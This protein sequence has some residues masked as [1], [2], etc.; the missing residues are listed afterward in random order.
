V[1]VETLGGLGRELELV[2]RGTAR[3]VLQGAGEAGHGDAMTHAAFVVCDLARPVDGDA[4]ARLELARAEH[5]DGS[6]PVREQDPLGGSASVGQQRVGADGEDGGHVARRR[7]AADVPDRVDAAVEAVPVPVSD[8]PLQDAATHIEIAQ[9]R[10][11][12]ASVLP[13]GEVGDVVHASLRHDL[14]VVMPP[15]RWKS[16]VSTVRACPS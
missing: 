9:L 15:E 4:G 6:G 13:C 3:E 12:D 10:P 1:A 11:G 5:V 8:A 16:A 14:T 2:R 7:V